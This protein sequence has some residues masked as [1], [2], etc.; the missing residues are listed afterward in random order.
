MGKILL[1]KTTYQAAQERIKWTFDNFEQV[2]ISFSGGKDSSV[3]LN[4]FYDYAKENNLLDRLAVY[5]LD[6]EAQYQATTNFVTEVF[7]NQFEGI[8]K[9]W[10]CLPIEAQCCCRMDSSHWTPW[11]KDQ[12]DIWVRDFPK[13]PYL[14]TEDN[15]PFK[16]EYGKTD[17]EMQDIFNNW[18]ASKYGKTA[19]V[20]GIRAEES[21]SRYKLVTSSADSLN[22][23]RVD[24]KKWTVE[25]GD[26][27][28]VY[29]I[30]DWAVEDV[31]TYFG[32]YDKKYNPLYD[33]YYKAG[34]T[35]HQMRVASPFNNQA[36]ATLKFYKVIDPNMWGKMCSRVNGVS[37]M[38][39]YGDTKLMGWRKITKPD[40]FTWKEYFEFLLSYY[41]KEVQEKLHKK[42]EKSIKSWDEKH[43]G[44]MEEKDILAL[45]EE[46]A[47]ITISA[48]KNNSTK[49]VV[50]YP[51]GYM[52]DTTIQN[53]RRVP[54][55][56]RACVCLLKND[57]QMKYMGFTLDHDEMKKRAEALER[58]RG[59]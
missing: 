8:K 52:D 30:Y 25:A 44:A 21:Y 46:G 36:N 17:N 23:H 13:S 50:H 11:A 40:N 24:N 10:L 2:M 45:L 28:R 15:A 59:L 49:R 6:Y 51:N 47:P 7:N 34:L 53:F 19:V 27:C 29:P 33:L 16:I 43:G 37:F 58:F 12:K 31:W 56:K 18:F 26:T 38:G 42:I 20:I 1:G 32:T 39:L 3:C 41:P 14:V 35:I 4:L 54:T 5:H 22:L 48:P 57:L 9:Y 55:W